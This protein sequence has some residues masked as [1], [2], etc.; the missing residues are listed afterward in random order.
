MISADDY[1]FLQTLLHQQSGLSLGPGKEY[2]I[3]SRLTPVA[4]TLGYGPLNVL[5]AYLRKGVAPAVVKSVCD[6][7]TTNETLFFRDTTPF[8]HFREVL[9]PEAAARARLQ[10]RAVRI[11]SAACSTGQEAY[12]LSMIIEQEERQLGGARIEILGTDYSTAAVQR[13][14]EGVFNQF[15]VQRGLPIQQLLQY[16]TKTGD[17][18]RINDPLRKRVRF[19]EGNLL[20]PF[21]DLGTF[22]IIFVRNVLIY[23]DQATKKDILERMSRQI[24]PGGALV[25]G[26]TEN[27]I[28]VT[29]ALVRDPRAVAPIYRRASEALRAVAA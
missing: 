9:L 8:K 16:F 1:K 12:S 21:G 2:L 7:M 3:E 19:Q 4:A 6:A 29:E 25:L 22:D 18:F 23:F 5:I 24:L 15:E 20:K 27:T 14:R 13:A 10:G 11:W 17:G 26:G 28:G